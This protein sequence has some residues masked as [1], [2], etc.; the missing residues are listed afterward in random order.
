MI[1]T[2]ASI[3]PS[4]PAVGQLRENV[5]HARGDHPPHG[6]GEGIPTH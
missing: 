6:P 4:S 2:L 3:D 1:A 5:A